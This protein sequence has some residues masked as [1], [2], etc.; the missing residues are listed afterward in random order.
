MSEQTIH[1]SADMADRPMPAQVR[2]L[3][4]YRSLIWTMIERD[5]RVRYKN[6]IL[7]IF[8][9]MITPLAQAFVLTIVIGFILGTGPR[10]Q[11]AYILCAFI[12]WFFFQ[13][14]I[15]DASQ[16]VLSQIGL[17][18]KIY[19]P[20]EI[21][22]IATTGASLIHMC[23]SLVVFVIYRWGVLSLVF[24]SWPGMPP[25][26]ILFLPVI[27]LILFL[28]TLGLSLLVAA[29]NVFYEDVK[30]IVG[31]LLML[32][33]YLAP[34]MYFP[35]SIFYSPRIPEHWRWLLYHLYLAN[36]ICWTIDA[37]KQAFFGRI[38]MP[39]GSSMRG[40]APCGP[41]AMVLTAPLS[42]H[43]CLLALV[44][45]CIVCVYGYNKFN[46]A[47]WTFTERP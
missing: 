19:F 16:A 10:S 2:E 8:W 38:V 37:F 20:R 47:K 27:I 22:V 35:E 44:L 36:P 15:M 45:S 3:W 28:L 5:L 29:M 25:K 21:P 1:I 17:I 12:P 46:A 39:I 9:S 30:F 24:R 6:S 40:S 7:G 11:S 14:A 33:M 32:Q 31:V 4:N 13:T 26:Q 43:F 42:L 23:I 34:I 18:K 41:H